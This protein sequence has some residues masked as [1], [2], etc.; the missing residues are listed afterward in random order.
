MPAVSQ[1][2]PPCPR[3]VTHPAYTQNPV[4]EIWK[5]FQNFPFWLGHDSP[6]SVK[7]FLELLDKFLK[8]HN[9]AKYTKPE[10]KSHMADNIQLPCRSNIKSP[11]L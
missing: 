5:F 2:V 9:L 4:D 8:K 10:R 7:N 3:I 1:H 6:C 11:E